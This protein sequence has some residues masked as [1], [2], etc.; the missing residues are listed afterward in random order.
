MLKHLHSHNQQFNQALMRLTLPM[1]LIGVLL[2]LVNLGGPVLWYDES[3]TAWMASLPFW[4]MVA[5]TAGDTHPPL[6]LAL[7]WVWVR[8]FGSDE[9][10]LRLPSVIFSTLAIVLVAAIGK[11]LHMWHGATLLAAALMAVLPAQL[12]YAQETRMYAL[13]QFE[14]LLGMWA[15]LSRR[16]W[17]MCM[18]LA[19]MLWTHNYGLLYFPVIAAIGL[20]QVRL[21]C[22]EENLAVLISWPLRRWGLACIVAAGSWLVW[23]TVLVAQMRAVADGY[24]LQPITPGD[25]LYPFYFLAWGF[26]GIE[27]TQIPAALITFG[28]IGFAI[29]KTFRERHRPAMMLAAAALAPWALAIIISLTWRPM[30]LFRGLVPST[31]LLCLL[32]A[33]ALTYDTSRFARWAVTFAAVP[34][35]VASVVSYY[36]NISDQK[37][38]V[39]PVIATI[40]WQPG[41]MIYHVNDGSLMAF[42][43]YTPREWPQYIMPREWRNLGALSDTTWAAMQFN[44]A[45]LSDVPSWHRAWLIYSASPTTAAAED[46]AVKRLLSHYLHMTVMDT[47]SDVTHQAVYLLWND[48]VGVP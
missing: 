22:E 18:A 34:L 30:L 19:A 21:Q 31:G 48:R 17:V 32:V 27:T 9:F 25:A 43:W 15:A 47:V 28:L 38:G 37:G 44:V 36:V 33:W 40:E 35:L 11:R 46:A 13:F 42:R 45:P 16:W 8:A 20:W 5:A 1:L 4:R 7:M 39:L 26:S 29:V 23:L 2:R 3:G 10:S 12:H 24:W 6:Y 14:F 41:D